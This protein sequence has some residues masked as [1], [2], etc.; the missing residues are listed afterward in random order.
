MQP[1]E[2]FQHN[3]AP[4]PGQLIF[5]QFVGGE[6]ACRL[7]DDGYYTR[8]GALLLDTTGLPAQPLSWQ[9]IRTTAA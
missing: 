4:V 8:T 1:V 7:E 3:P 2:R 9:P 5:G 6:Y